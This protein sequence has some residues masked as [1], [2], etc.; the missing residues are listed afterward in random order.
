MVKKKKTKRKIIKWSIIS[1]LVVG[2]IGF[3]VYSSNHRDPTAGFKSETVQTKN[4]ATYYS[5]SGTVVPDKA[6]ELTAQRNIKIKEFQVEK[7]DQVKAGDLLYVVDD[8]DAAASLEQAAAAVELAEIGYR[9]AVNG[10]SKQQMIQAESALSSA[11]LSLE[12]A[13]KTFERTQQL[14]DEGMAS[15][16]DLD[17]AQRGLNL[18][19][20]QYDTAKET[21]DLTADTLV[22]ASV[23]S[24][25]AQLRQ[26]Q[27]SYE[28]VR[29]QV[30]D[31]EIY[32]EADGEV[33]AVYPETG[34]LLPAGTPVM[35]I[36]NYSAMKATIKVDEYDVGAL[37]LGNDA[38]VTVNALEKELTGKVS[39]LSKKATTANGISYFTADITLPEDQTLL[40]GMSVEVKVLN[41]SVE[42]ATTISMKALQFD[43]EN[44][45]YVYCL[46]E[47]G[48][49]VQRPVQVGINDGLTVEIL[50]GLTPGETVY[51]PQ[52]AMSMYMSAMM[53]G[54]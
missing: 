22:G 41:Q 32:A 12:D 31:I 3:F 33:T 44:N 4:V 6:S 18:A 45:P 13:K 9:N 54:E 29:D 21:Y 40:E 14:F 42:N 47:K 7:G 37:R 19:Q 43:Y 38:A 24:A 34:K 16:S 28:S 46:D 26:A 50:E 25:R 23:E 15:Q 35:D 17:Q 20:Q 36:T 53:G 30:G 39:D 8:S 52:T 5:F 1:V 10:T 2:V 49:M 48:K 11:E 27:A 51:F